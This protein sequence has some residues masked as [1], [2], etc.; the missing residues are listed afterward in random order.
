MPAQ[1]NF[2]KARYS[3]L[4][5][6]SYSL[7][8]M[9][10]VSQ[11]KG[12]SSNLQFYQDTA[13]WILPHCHKCIQ[14]LCTRCSH[15]AATCRADQMKP[16]G[17][18]FADSANI[19]GDLYIVESVTTTCSIRSHWAP[20]MDWELQNEHTISLDWKVYIKFYD[21]ENL[22]KGKQIGSF[23]RINL[24]LTGTHTHKVSTITLVHMRAER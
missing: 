5:Q 3:K 16:R 24:K 17:N 18:V 23:C 10:S 13:R 9:I 22:A 2:W 14:V 6:S 11:H 1:L 20:F 7:K 19:V 12:K 15:S 21:L 4:T 8:F